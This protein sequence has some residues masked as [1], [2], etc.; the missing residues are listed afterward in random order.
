[1][2]HFYSLTSGLDN[3]TGLSDDYDAFQ[4]TPAT[5]QSTDTITGGA[6]GSFIDLIIVTQAGTISGSQFS[7]VSKIEQ[8]NLTSG[9]NNVTLTDGLVAG[10][11]IGYFAV[12]DGGGSDTIDASAISTK[13]V[14]FFATSGNDTFKGGHGNDAVALAATDLTSA[15]TIQGGGGIDNL[16]LG[17]AG[18]VTSSSFANVSGFEGLVLA[19]G[20]NNVTLTNGF[21]ANTS[22]GYVAVAGGTGDTV[23]ASSVTNGIPIAF[24]GT[25]GGN[26]SFTGGS[27]GDSFLFAAGQLTAADTVVGGGGSD[28]LW[29][30]TAGTTGTAALAHVSG[31]EGV[32]LQNGGT[33]NFADGITT[34]AALAAVGSAAVDTLDAS[35][36]T[37]YGVTFVG[38]GGADVLKGGSR[39]DTFFMADENFASIDG[40]AGIDRLTL[41]EADASFN[42]STTAARLH[43]IEVVSMDNVEHGHVTLT[44]TDI[45][46]ISSN[47]ALYLVGDPGDSYTAGN[48]YTQLASGVTNNA[49]APGHTFFEFQHSSGSILYVDSSMFDLQSNDPVIDVAPENSPASRVVYT[50][51][52]IFPAGTTVAHTLGGADA[53]LFDIDSASGNVTFKSSADFE[54]PQDQDHNNRYEFTVTTSND[55]AIPTT[56]K[57][58]DAIVTD[59]N[60]NAPVFT[61]GA[62]AAT[63]ENVAT[64]TVVYTAAAADADG[65]P[66]NRTVTYSLSSGGD[67]DLFDV[68]VASGGLTFKASPDYEAPMDGNHDNQYDIVVTASDG[69]PAHNAM[70]HVAINVSDVLLA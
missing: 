17:S 57:T 8:L 9:G 40:N 10:T 33:F 6:A 68:N 41:T 31:I 55:A 36:V 49:V 18:T 20:T 43:N 3:F 1:V 15:D 37:A 67:N 2:A 42:L 16:Y 44:G 21:V 5:L 23:D 13:P 48:G 34:A 45:T 7:G 22:I 14:V 25:Q 11:G 27:G 63:P 28:T 26:D 64:T 19:N 66:A 47:N 29:I 61:S 52:S 39:D 30:T 62:S 70:L 59:V 35:A 32:F 69:L 4:L 24:F 54:N 56:A 58:V 12:V 38:N 46:Q 60:D 65:T 51:H 50:D 53:A